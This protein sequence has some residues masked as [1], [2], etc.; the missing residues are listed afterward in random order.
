MGGKDEEIARTES[1]TCEYA[2]KV[3]YD[4]VSALLVGGRGNKSASAAIPDGNS[5]QTT[6][7][8]SLH[9]ILSDIKLLIPCGRYPAPKYTFLARA[10]VIPGWF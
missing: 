1:T 6:D 2:R 10:Q 3:V 9:D 5:S 8:V 7:G 4:G